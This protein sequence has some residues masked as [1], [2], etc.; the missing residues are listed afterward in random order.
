LKKGENLV[1][2]MITGDKT[3][4]FAAPSSSDKTADRV[5]AVVIILSCSALVYAAVTWAG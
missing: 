3:M 2:P 4:D 5:K 1:R